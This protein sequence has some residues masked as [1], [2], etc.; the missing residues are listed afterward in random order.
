MA[1][2]RDLTG[3]GY[4]KPEPHYDE[5]LTHVGRGTSM[6]ELLRRYWHPVGLV[7]D[8]TSTP[9]EVRVLGE[10]LILFRDGQGRPGLVHSRCA[11]RGTSLYY[12]TVDDRGIRCCYHGWLFDV[13]GHVLEQPCEPDLGARFRGKVRQPW[14]PVQEQY[15]L[16]FAYMGPPEKMPVLPRYDCFE[17]LSPQEALK[18][19]DTSIGTEGD[20]IMPVN[21][22]QHFENMADPYHVPI[23]HKKDFRQ[24]PQHS[25]FKDTGRG[26]AVGP[27]EL[28][29]D[30]TPLIFIAEAVIPTLRVVTSPFEKARAVGW[31]MPIDDTH[32]RNYTVT[33]I[34]RD[35]PKRVLPPSVLALF[36]DPAVWKTKTRE[37]R[38]EKPG[39]WEAQTGQGPQTIHSEEHL[40]MSDRGVVMLRKML[41]EQLKR[42]DRGEDPI[43]V[44]FDPDTPP[45]KLMDGTFD[46]PPGWGEIAAE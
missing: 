45:V 20:V 10:D 22:L 36:N 35:A 4:N 43:N 37:E 9:K 6:G 32:F 28:L 24:A 14:Y 38:R 17:N 29:P 46:P 5:S 1:T 21:W 12:G 41:R 18:V 33:R 39:D 30:G 8:A 34:V 44:S 27:T 31:I 7:G 3:H 25:F 11:H 23:L 19:D 15:G 13:E 2:A 40:A 16:I 42:I 26:I